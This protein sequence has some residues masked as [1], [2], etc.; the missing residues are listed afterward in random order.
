M[1]DMVS[2]IYHHNA[3]CHNNKQYSGLGSSTT[4]DSE[5]QIQFEIF[6]AV[7][8]LSIP[9]IIAIWALYRMLHLS[10]ESLQ[11]INFYLNNPPGEDRSERHQPPHLDLSFLKISFF[12]KVNTTTT[13]LGLLRSFRNTCVLD[14]VTGSFRAQQVSAIMGPSGSGTVPS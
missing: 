11:Q 5:R 3:R 13:H 7:I 10:R 4:G 14:Q 8:Y 2:C 9:S 1:N 12:V 6:I